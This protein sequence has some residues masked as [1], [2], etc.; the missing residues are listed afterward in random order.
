MDKISKALRK[1]PSA[2]LTL[3]M[4]AFDKVLAGQPQGVNLKPMKGHKHIYRI[5]SGDYRL[6]FEHIPGQKAIIL[7]AGKRNDQ[8]YRDF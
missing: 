3:L 8:I 6:V 4:T 1:I 5:R 7:F 2:R